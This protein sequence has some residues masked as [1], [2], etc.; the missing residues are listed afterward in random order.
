[1]GHM[2]RKLLIVDDDQAM[3]RML[4][5]LFQDEGWH[6]DAAESVDE[7]LSLLSGAE[8]DAVLS[9]IRMGARS[10][11]ELAGELHRL[12]PDTPIV[13]MT[14]FG[15]DESAAEARRAGAMGYVSKPFEPEAVLHA[16][17]CALERRAAGP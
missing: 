8:Y 16:L 17:E 12:W 13:L 9:D 3:R 7:A 2:T 4:E 15:G 10:G 11:L 14:A 1:M 5:A 6:T